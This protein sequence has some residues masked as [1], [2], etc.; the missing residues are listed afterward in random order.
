MV[1]KRDTDEIK[2]AKK[3]E[4]NYASCQPNDIYQKFTHAP[5]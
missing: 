4:N 3:T 1:Y 2:L 5:A